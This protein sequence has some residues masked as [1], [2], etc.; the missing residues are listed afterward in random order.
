MNAATMDT[1]MLDILVE[2]HSFIQ[3]NGDVEDVLSIDLRNSGT[4][5]HPINCLLKFTYTDV[6]TEFICV[7]DKGGIWEPLHKRSVPIFE[8]LLVAPDE[9]LP[10]SAKGVPAGGRRILAVKV[11]RVGLADTDGSTLT[12][13]DPLYALTFP[14]L[15]P[16]HIA[17]SATVIF[18]ENKFPRK[19]RAQGAARATSRTATW[20]W[21]DALGMGKYLQMRVRQE[22]G[23]LP[24]APRQI[25]DAIAAIHRCLADCI[26]GE[27][28]ELGPL[29][30][31][32]TDLLSSGLSSD[33]SFLEANVFTTLDQTEQEARLREVLRRLH[34]LRADVI[35]AD[36]PL[37]CTNPTVDALAEWISRKIERQMEQA[38]I[39]TPIPPEASTALHALLLYLIYQRRDPT[40]WGKLLKEK[41]FQ[42][43]FQE[44]LGYRGINY[45]RE[46]RAAGGRVDFLIGST[47]VELKVCKLEGNP[48]AKLGDY[49]E[50]T[51]EYAAALNSGLGFLLVLDTY[52]YGPNS[53]HLPPPQDLVNVE[54]V[55]SAWGKEGQSYTVV[56]SVIVPAYPPQPSRMASA[57]KN[58]P[59]T[60]KKKRPDASL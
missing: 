43:R 44:F 41:D 2:R 19:L 28:L 25:D 51:A 47:P 23:V 32:L 37:D 54:P 12:F 18:P 58:Q 14:E 49:R 10:G 60:S 4:V 56:T 1:S 20:N 6:K 40:K 21:R 48:A 57:R 5:T 15:R 29:Q 55:P 50:Q 8:E 31:C 42:E 16:R 39:R 45:E 13:D 7:R 52:K 46:V 34:E 26:L 59:H 24:S 38:S 17:Y 27:A 30:A 36:S 35:T 11:R 53:P 3:T 9:E 22:H 33:V